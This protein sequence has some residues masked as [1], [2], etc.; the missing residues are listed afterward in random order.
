MV[1]AAKDGEQPHVDHPD[2]LSLLDGI[3]AIARN[4]L[5]YSDNP[6]DIERYQKLLDMSVRGYSDVLGVPTEELRRRF[7]S[8]AGHVSAKVGASVAAF[9][10]EGRALLARRADDGR[11]SLISGWIDPNE[12]PAD[13]AVRE[14]EEEVGLQGRVVE[15]VD[16]YSRAANFAN[17]PHSIVSVLYLCEVTGGRLS[18]EASTHEVLEAAYLHI[19]EVDAW[20]GRHRERALDARERWRARRV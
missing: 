4:G 9:D 17:G 1:A 20:H 2:L 15:L 10:D 19:E 12:A 3:Q 16:V 5:E 14:L 6:F 8:E 7:A 13:A 11:W 18:T